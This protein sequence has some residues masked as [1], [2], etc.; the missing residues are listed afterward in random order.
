MGSKEV[1]L[2][3]GKYKAKLQCQGH[4]TTDLNA[5]KIIAD[6]VPDIRASINNF[7]LLNSSDSQ[8][9]VEEVGFETH[10]FLR[11]FVL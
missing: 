1:G 8:G 5:I 6:C 9:A 7:V 10:S 2:A 3:F 11:R 4:V